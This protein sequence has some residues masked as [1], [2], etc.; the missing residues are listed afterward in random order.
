MNV[1]AWISWTPPHCS[2]LLGLNTSFNA[3]RRVD[4]G[5]GGVTRRTHAAVPRMGGDARRPRRRLRPSADG[6]A[7]ACRRGCRPDH[8]GKTPA[9]VLDTGRSARRIKKK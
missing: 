4:I 7:N 3:K 1:Y 2:F 8:R 9:P 5:G 6:A